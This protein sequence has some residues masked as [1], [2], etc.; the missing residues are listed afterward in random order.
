MESMWSPATWIQYRSLWRRITEFATRE[1][2]PMND[3]TMSLFIH[4]LPVTL[5][6]KHTYARTCINILNRLNQPHDVLTMYDKALKSS[7]AEIPTHQAEPML[8]DDLVRILPRVRPLMAYG[9][10]LAWKTASRWDEIA[11]LQHKS[12]LQ[13]NDDEIVLYFGSETK[14]SRATPFR[15][16]L[17]C[18]IR[19][20]WTHELA[21]FLRERM[22]LVPEGSPLIMIPTAEVTSTLATYGY[23]AHSLKRGA[24]SHVLAHLPEGSPLFTKMG[25]L[26]KHANSVPGISSIT[27]R[28]ME[29]QVQTARQLETGALTSLL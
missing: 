22:K 18:V 15:P 29:Q 25:L 11:R 19:G 23:S 28:Y 12:V 3:H 8:Y 7:G 24:L 6:S 17:F 16:E 2:L 27:L 26:A 21:L 20:R 13:T 5:S 10:M 1:N 4:H 14:T 9:L